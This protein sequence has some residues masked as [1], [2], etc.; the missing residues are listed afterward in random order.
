MLGQVSTGAIPSTNTENM[1]LTELYVQVTEVP[2]LELVKV[3]PDAGVQVAAAFLVHVSVYVEENVG[4]AVN[5]EPLAVPATYMV[6][7]Q[8]VTGVTMG[9]IKRISA[10][11]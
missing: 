7:G 6:L 1:Q 3:D 9:R 2:V 4:L 8:V 10:Q 11:I 5:E